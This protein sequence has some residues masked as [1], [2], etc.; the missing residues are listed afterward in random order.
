MLNNIIKHLE[1]M[2]QGHGRCIKKISPVEPS[3]GEVKEDL[4]DRI[5]RFVH[6]FE[7]R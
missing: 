2:K 1:Q 6:A 5:R 4:Y 3:Q 7:N